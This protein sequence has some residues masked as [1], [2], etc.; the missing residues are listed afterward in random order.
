MTLCSDDRRRR[1][2][3]RQSSVLRSS[4]RDRGLGLLDDRR[5]SHGLGDCK[6]GQHLAIDQKPGF[7]EA[8][9]EPAVGQAEGAHRRIEALNPERP[10]RALAALA[11]A[12]GVLVRLLHGLLGDADGVLAPAVIALGGLED[13][14]VLGVRGNAALDA[15]H[16]G[17]PVVVRCDGGR[18]TPAQPLGRKY[19]LI[20]SPSVLNST[21]VPRSWRICFLVRLIMPWRLR[22]CW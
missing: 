1:T 17:S 15:C 8:V 16:G 22:D 4:R 5:K 13:F 20:L 9:D 7:V 2:V 12:V 19:F 21:L 6:I 18:R 14:L 3:C 11:V 10:E